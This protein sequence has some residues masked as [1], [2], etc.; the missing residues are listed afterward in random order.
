MECSYPT[1]KKLSLWMHLILSQSPR[2]PS[3][4]AIPVLDYDA[5]QA[6]LAGAGEQRSPIGIDRFLQ[7]YCT[8]SVRQQIL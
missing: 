6:V 7:A 3:E 5:F 1:M 2:C 8:F 4:G